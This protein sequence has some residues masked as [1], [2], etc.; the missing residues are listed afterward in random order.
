MIYKTNIELNKT[1]D[2]RYL[3]LLKSILTDY[4]R[5]D[6]VE[7]IKL[8]DI[9]RTFLSTFYDLLNIIIKKSGFEIQKR[10]HT[11]KEARIN[12]MDWPTNAETMIGLKRLENIEFCVKEIIANN[13]QGDLIETGVWRGGGV[14]F[15]KALLETLGD[16]TRKVFVADS[17]EGLPKPDL[18]KYIAD[19]GDE[20]YKQY[21]LSI[22]EEIVR[23]NF[24]KY[25]LLDERVIF[26]KGWFADT[27]Q[28]A[29]IEKLSLLRLDGDMY[30]STMDA[31]R[32]LY[33]KLSIGGFVIVDDYYAVEGCK[34][35]ITDYRKEFNI[36]SELIAID[37]T[38]VYW[39]KEA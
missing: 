27:L 3:D 38:A 4:N 12:G 34:K 19:K 8:K 22:G 23:Q 28:N 37:Q 29:P 6:E 24:K 31:I 17:F 7:Y 33:P 13:I 21:R 16:I 9:N 18:K 5:L 2:Q 32:P 20:H 39:R 26:I 36:D 15:M 1:K 10:I 35:A 11:T 30:G 14:I 25:N